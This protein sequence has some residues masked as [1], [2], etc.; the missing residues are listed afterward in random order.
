MTGACFLVRRDLFERFGGFDDRYAPAFYEEFDL[1]T[2]LRDA[3]H[4]IV[5]QPAS[6]VVHHGSASYGTEIRD[7]QSKRNHAKFCEKW[8]TLLARQ[9]ARDNPIFLVRERP[10]P[11]PARSRSPRGLPS[12]ARNGCRAPTP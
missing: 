6:V 1:A 9:Q 10:P 4:H 5:Y 7:R 11:R 3:G 2:A 8:R 12:S